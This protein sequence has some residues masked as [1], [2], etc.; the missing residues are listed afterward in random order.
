MNPSDTSSLIGPDGRPCFGLYPSPLTDL[1]LNDFR[2]YGASDAASWAKK[3]ILKYRLKQWAY[4]GVCDSDIVFGMAIV[5]LGYMCNLFAYLFDRRTHRISE[6]SLVTPGGSAANFVGTSQAGKITFASGKTTVHMTSGPDA[7]SLDGSIRG[8]LA[9]SLSFQKYAEPLVCLTRVGI[10]GFN[11][12]HKEAG[13]AAQGTIRHRGAAWEIHKGRSFGVMD[14][15]LG[16]L[17]RHTF[18]N[19][20]AGG[21]TDRQ[22]N[23]LGF[24]LAQGINETGFTEN[25]FWVNGHL[26]KTDVAD[27]R[28]DDLD[29]MK[30]WQ[31][32]TNDGRVRLRFLPEGKRTGNTLLGVIVSRIH[33]PFG[34]FEGSLQ[35]GERIYELRDVSGFTEEHYAKW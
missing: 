18:W 35:D 31:V 3:G 12:T 34:R 13:I 19:W 20:A 28:H 9:V 16:Y 1:N 11:Y 21:G 2:P 26:V 14:F 10:K 7:V 17:G 23:R 27:F 32:E 8:E 29:I 25:A 22:G 15:T 24:N 5:R 30:P 6:Y 4:L 33:Q